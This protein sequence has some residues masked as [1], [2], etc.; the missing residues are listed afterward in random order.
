MMR[1]GLLPLLLVCFSPAACEPVPDAGCTTAAAPTV[2]LGY[3]DVDGDFVALADGDDVVI[4]TA[5]QGGY[6]VA[7]WARTTGLEA[8]DDSRTT[9]IVAT[10]IGGEEAGRFVLYQ[11]PL[12]CVAEAGLVT[13]VVVPLDPERFTGPETLLPL[14]GA[15]ATLVVDIVDNNDAVGHAEQLVTLRVDE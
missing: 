11:Q 8:D 4:T 10:E 15:A 12:L 6:G 14:D 7:V 5:P 13:T 1:A 9:V 3:G 2:Q